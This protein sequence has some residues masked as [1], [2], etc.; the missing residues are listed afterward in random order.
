MQSAGMEAI[1]SQVIEQLKEEIK[2]IS[3][4]KMDPNKKKIFFVDFVINIGINSSET[5][6]LGAEGKSSFTKGVHKMIYNNLFTFDI[7][8]AMNATV[9]TVEVA[10]GKGN[11]TLS[12]KQLI[13]THDYNKSTPIEELEFV[14]EVTS[15]KFDCG[16]FTDFII[17]TIK[18]QFV[19][20]LNAELKG[21][22]EKHRNTDPLK[23]YENPSQPLT[24]EI[25]ISLDRANVTSL[26]TDKNMT[27][28]IDSNIT[29]GNKSEK[30]TTAC[31]AKENNTTFS[32]CY[33]PY[34]FPQMLIFSERE[35]SVVLDTWEMKGKAIE[36]YEILPGLINYYSPEVN[37]TVIRKAIKLLNSSSEVKHE[38][39]KEYTFKIGQEM[40]LKVTAAFNLA[41]E[42]V[43]ETNKLFVKQSEV[44]LTKIETA[45]VI[46]PAGRTV[47][48]RL[49]L[50]E[51]NYMTKNHMFSEG[52]SVK[53]GNQTSKDFCFTLDTTT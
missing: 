21:I 29:Y 6:I 42:G 38:I 16:V 9:Q 31:T 48:A 12:G 35:E 40:V 10:N 33:C 7:E 47:L 8:F 27:R 37:Y 43:V 41:L 4:H 30:L 3:F 26:P 53:L 13:L 5:N 44:N 19:A 24:N 1:A 15:L 50:A 14:I 49:M 17:G 32:I 2:G 23:Q 11:I 36:L 46:Q 39:A 20:R 18:K 34:M 22:I 25:L 52:I 51:A 45:G 28:L